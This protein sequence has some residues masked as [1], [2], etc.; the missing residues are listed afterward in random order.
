ASST[1]NSVVGSVVNTVSDAANY[2]SET[3]QQYTSQA[4]KEGNK[5]VA[6]GHTDASLTQ[7]ASA[8]IDALG[9]KAKEESHAAKAEGYSTSAKN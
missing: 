5:E 6:K 1:S 9:D 2:V 4:S 7:R 3:V 8:G